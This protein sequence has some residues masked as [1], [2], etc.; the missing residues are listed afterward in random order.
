MDY[1]FEDSKED[2]LI[3]DYLF[4]NYK[5]ASKSTFGLD[6]QFA[7]PIEDEDLF[8]FD[9]RLESDQNDEIL[10][11][12]ADSPI[13][14]SPTPLDLEEEEEDG[15]FHGLASDVPFDKGPNSPGDIFEDDE[16]VRLSDTDSNKRNQDHSQI[17]QID[18]IFIDDYSV[19][20]D[21]RQPCIEINQ[22]NE[23]LR[24]TKTFS[25]TKEPP[26]PTP[27]QMKLQRMKEKIRESA[28]R[29]SLKKPEIGTGLKDDAEIEM[30]IDE[31]KLVS[32]SKS[33]LMFGKLFNKTKK[34]NDLHRS[35]VC[36]KV[37]WDVYSQSLRKRICAQKRKVWDSFQQPSEAF[38][39][40]E[41]LIEVPD[42][43]KS[44]EIEDENVEASMGE[45]DLDQGTPEREETG[46]QDTSESEAYGYH[47]LLE[48]DED[49][50]Q[51]A[52]ECGDNG[53]Q[54]PF[55]SDE[56]ENHDVSEGDGDEDSS[57]LQF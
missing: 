45:E 16:I 47:D 41:E 57:C 35:P 6:Q 8:G 4:S 12:A 30:L 7:K 53:N 26:P 20:P 5:P 11:R 36:D 24:S 17:Q 51:D 9:A 15:P 29:I 33:K 54:D 48:S 13:N 34:A 39:E 52:S 46:N 31:N 40:E 43:D 1:L 19:S 21:N 38:D 37:S 3:D 42:E 55:E 44:A 28:M 18:E 56:G 25:K 22:D 23:V 49:G 32:D 27:E 10:D 14:A 50:D 2:K